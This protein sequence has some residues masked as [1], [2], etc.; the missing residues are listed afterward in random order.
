[1]PLNDILQQIAP[2]MQQEQQQRE[3]QM[4]WALQQQQQAAA[5]QQHQDDLA[6]RQSALRQNQSQFDA[7]HRQQQ[8]QFDYAKRQSEHDKELQ[9]ATGMYEANSRQGLPS[10]HPQQI[11]L[12]NRMGKFGPEMAQA[13][14]LELAQRARKQLEPLLQV[15]RNKMDKKSFNMLNSTLQDVAATMHPEATKL[16]PWQMFGEGLPRIE[17]GG[18]INAPLTDFQKQGFDVINKM[19]E[20]RTQKDELAKQQLLSQQQ[21]QNMNHQLYG[22]MYQQDPEIAA[23]Q[24]LEQSRQVGLARQRA[25]QEQL[26]QGISPWAFLGF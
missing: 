18:G 21:T 1:M 3:M 22:E 24:L 23:Q 9:Y 8:D 13:A 17:G 25:A 26:K 5:Q 6:Y 10:T 2:F 12:A 19:R 20:A 16:F 7:G 14:Y 11:A 4:R 15:Y